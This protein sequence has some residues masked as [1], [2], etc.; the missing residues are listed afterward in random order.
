MS[1]NQSKI[2]FAPKILSTNK[3]R[4]PLSSIRDKLPRVIRLLSKFSNLLTPTK[5]CNSCMKTFKFTPYFNDKASVKTCYKVLLPMNLCQLFFLGTFFWYCNL[6]YVKTLSSYVLVFDPFR[7][8]SHQKF[9]LT[10]FRY[11][12]F[13]SF[14]LLTTKSITCFNQY[15]WL[16]VVN[17]KGLQ[18]RKLIN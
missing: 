14:T 6:I 8:I 5:F 11:L 15:R 16:D 13:L 9:P 18:L 2:Q 1:S 10:L 7:P 12:F 4:H 3:S 17:N